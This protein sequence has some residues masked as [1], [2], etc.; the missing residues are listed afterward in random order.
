[1]GHW[2]ANSKTLWNTTTCGGWLSPASSFHVL[3]TPIPSLLPPFVASTLTTNPKVT[4]NDVIISHFQ[5]THTIFPHAKVGEELGYSISGA[6]A[7]HS[8]HFHPFLLS[9]CPLPSRIS[10]TNT[11]LRFCVGLFCPNEGLP[12]LWLFD[13]ICFLKNTHTTPPHTKAKIRTSQEW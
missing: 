3:G 4:G 6:L 8:P 9:H 11:C 5:E 10:E 2:L 12:R 7:Y 13:L 1:M